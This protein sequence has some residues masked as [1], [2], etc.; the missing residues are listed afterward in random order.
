MK[1]KLILLL[2]LFMSAGI[3]AE[4]KR[5]AVL[6]TVDRQNQLSYN[7]KRHLLIRRLV[8]THFYFCL[9]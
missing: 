1:T 7:Q 4:V 8:Y 5:I 6:E 3:Y 2:M 9:V